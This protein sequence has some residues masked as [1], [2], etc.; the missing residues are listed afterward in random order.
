MFQ[1]VENIHVREQNKAEHPLPLHLLSVTL[2][3]T[4]NIFYQNKNVGLVKK[5]WIKNT[6]EKNPHMNCRGYNDRQVP[7][8]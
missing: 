5:S 7:S 8:V 1:M 4:N 6:M 2:Q 3:Q